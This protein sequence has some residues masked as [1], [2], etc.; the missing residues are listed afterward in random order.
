MANFSDEAI[1]ERLDNLYMNDES[2]LTQKEQEFVEQLL[3]EHDKAQPLTARQ[4][5]WALDILDDHGY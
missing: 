5:S 1:F 2:T 3:H 4:S